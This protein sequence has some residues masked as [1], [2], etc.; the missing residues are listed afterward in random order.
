MFHAV[1]PDSTEYTIAVLPTGMNQM[2]YDFK[3]HSNTYPSDDAWAAVTQWYTVT[4]NPLNSP[5][6]P[7]RYIQPAGDA[8]QFRW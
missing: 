8:I 2:I 6:H 3:G 5:A 4:E 7:P 1:A